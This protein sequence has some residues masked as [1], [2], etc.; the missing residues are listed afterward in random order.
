MRRARRHPTNE[1]FLREGRALALQE[2]E[3]IL[4]ALYCQECGLNFQANLALALVG[5][6]EEDYV[7]ILAERGLWDLE[8]HG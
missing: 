1:A 3:A 7:H 8:Q 5:W 2:S 4:H 6:S